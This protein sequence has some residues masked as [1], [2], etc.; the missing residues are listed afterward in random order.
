MGDIQHITKINSTAIPT[1]DD[2]VGLPQAKWFIAI[3]NN[4][5]EKNNA[6]K[7]TKMGI[8]NYVPLQ[9][10][11]HVWSNGKRVNVEKVMI[12]S[13]I[14]IR[15]TERERRNI[16]NL[17]FIFRFMTNKAGVSTNSVSKPLAVVP[18]HE[19][20]QLKFMLGVKD[21]KVAFTERFVKG[22][23]VEVRRGPFKGLTGVVLQDAGNKTN[24]L[25][26]NIDFLGCAYVEI[27]PKDVAPCKVND[28]RL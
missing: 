28:M 2:A 16:V 9:K 26:I 4:R 17:P 13:K 20:E 11:L 8:E 23:K 5:S 10:E 15:C 21:A 7:L 3:V 24:H 27:N 12:P 6:G 19:I 25:Y 22:D 18:D 1:V 14:F